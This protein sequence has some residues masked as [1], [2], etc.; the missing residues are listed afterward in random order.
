MDAGNRN[1]ASR[2]GKSERLAKQDIATALKL[3]FNVD[4]NVVRKHRE[5]VE[6]GRAGEN[7]TP[8]AA[9]G[10]WAGQF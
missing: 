8:D 10:V 1:V 7:F 3:L 2:D 6:S 9:P 5:F 4:D